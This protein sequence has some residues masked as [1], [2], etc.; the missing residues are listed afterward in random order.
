MTAATAGDLFDG[1]FECAHCGLE[2]TARVFASSSGV[3]RGD[4][5]AAE[6]HATEAAMG[7]AN[8]LAARTLQFVHCPECGQ[9]DPTGRGYRVQASLGAIVLGA[10]G[11]LLFYVYAAMRAMTL[12]H[13]SSTGDRRWRVSRARFRGSA[14]LRMTDRIPRKT[15]PRSGLP[16]LTRVKPNGLLPVLLFALG[17]FLAL[18]ATGE[19]VIALDPALLP[20][21]ALE[22][23][24]MADHQTSWALRGWM[25]GSN[26]VNL[27][28]AV[29][30]VRSARALRRAEARGWRL[31][32]VAT[33]ALAG[34][35][36]VGI[37]VCLPHLL[38]LPAGPIGEPSELMLVSVVAAGLG[39]ATMS[40]VLFGVAHRAVRRQRASGGGTLG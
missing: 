8:A 11:G 12:E 7:S 23:P 30:L 33:G 26:L 36:L 24:F 32:R 5:V 19:I 35:A 10:V 27:A 6:Q 15:Q 31:L 13:R 28:C 17:G 22:I 29:T 20:A 18:G 40:L 3:A 39:V 14:V 16:H 4:D 38:P 37:A 21:E 9:T 25:L 1:V 34:T 2:A